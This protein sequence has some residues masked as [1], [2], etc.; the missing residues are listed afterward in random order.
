MRYGT[1]FI[2]CWGLSRDKDEL[3]GIIQ[4]LWYNIDRHYTSAFMRMRRSEAECASWHEVPYHGRLRTWYNVGTHS[5][6]CEYV[7]HFDNQEE[8]GWR[9]FHRRRDSGC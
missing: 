1:W 3:L 6:V 4:R 9:I 7:I 2:R 5:Y 8:E